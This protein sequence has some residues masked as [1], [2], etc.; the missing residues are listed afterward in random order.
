VEK[1][2]GNM[3]IALNTENPLKEG[4]EPDAVLAAYSEKAELFAALC[5]TGGVASVEEDTK[6][7]KT[8]A[9]SRFE[10]ARSKQVVVPLNG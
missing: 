1:A 9:P 2:V 3:C 5:P 8:V 4:A 7:P 6:A 10:A